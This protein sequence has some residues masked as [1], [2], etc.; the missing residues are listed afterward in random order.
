MN[1]EYRTRDERPGVRS[2]DRWV[3]RG[4][5]WYIPL[6]APSIMQLFFYFISTQHRSSV[7]Q[8][9]FIAAQKKTK[10]TT[11]CIHFLMLKMLYK[12]FWL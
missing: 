1:Y 11:P 12:C 4:F 10:K 3:K 9:D 6:F 2:E 8:F 7:P 5:F